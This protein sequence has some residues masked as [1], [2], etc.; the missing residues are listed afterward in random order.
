MFRQPVTNTVV[1]C[2]HQA[3]RGKYGS[4]SKE[5][6]TWQQYVMPPHEVVAS[7]YAYDERL[8]HATFCGAPGDLQEWW[9]HNMDHAEHFPGLDL[10]CALPLRLY[11][12]G[13]DSTRSQHFEIVTLLPTLACSHTTRDSRIVLSVRSAV[14]TGHKALELI[15]EVLAW[16]FEALRC[17]A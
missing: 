9:L 17:P 6:T 5:Q 16:S 2:M 4:S 13:A 1:C 10:D 8:F 11:G 3:R 14:H 7:F 12:D 15:S